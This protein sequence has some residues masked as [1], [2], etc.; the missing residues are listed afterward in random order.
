[1]SLFPGDTASAQGRLGFIN[2]PGFLLSDWKASI[3]S[4]IAQEPDAMFP[5]HGTF[6]FS[7]AKDHLLQ[8]DEKLNAPWVNIVTSIG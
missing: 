3:K 6:I 8:Y 1:V 5:G 2:G 7:G 4:M